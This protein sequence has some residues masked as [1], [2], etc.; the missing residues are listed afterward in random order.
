MD[1]EVDCIDTGAEGPEC[2]KKRSTCKRRSYMVN[3][4]YR[5]TKKLYHK[6]T[7]TNINALNVYKT[8]IGIVFT[9][10]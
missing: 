6:N 10:Y 4:N 1:M 8:V 9:T 7:F 3:I 2:C 5:K